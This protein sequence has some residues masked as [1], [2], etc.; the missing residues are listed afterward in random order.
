MFKRKPTY[1]KKL[2]QI[3]SRISRIPQEELP[4]WADQAINDAGRALTA[5]RRRGDQAEL[6]EAIL[7]AEALAAILK[8][9]RSR[10]Y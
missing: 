8:N 7:G 5:W 9:I 2:S 6:E 4:I 3:E 1:E 10:A